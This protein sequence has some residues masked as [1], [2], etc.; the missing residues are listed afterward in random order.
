MS[1][2]FPPLTFVLARN[3]HGRFVRAPLNEVAV[4]SPPS[5]NGSAAVPSKPPP[6]YVED[7]VEGLCDRFSLGLVSQEALGLRLARL[8][9]EPFQHPLDIDWVL[10]ERNLIYLDEGNGCGL[11]KGANTARAHKKRLREID[12]D[13]AFFLRIKPWVPERLRRKLLAPKKGE[14]LK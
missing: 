8:V 7:S 3:E 12:S 10:I 9:L 14:T 5:G 2:A 1:D 11:W 13:F 6:Y 4:K